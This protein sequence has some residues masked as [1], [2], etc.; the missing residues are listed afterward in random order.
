MMPFVTTT[1]V[2]NDFVKCKRKTVVYCDDVS[3]CEEA[4]YWLCKQANI[5]CRRHELNIH[6]GHGRSERI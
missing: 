5:Y 1:I 2:W 3:F 4:Y 6:E